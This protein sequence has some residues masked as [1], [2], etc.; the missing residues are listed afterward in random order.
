DRLDEGGNRLHVLG[1][2]LLKVSEIVPRCHYQAVNIKQ[3]VAASRGRQVYPLASHREADPLGNTSGRRACAEEQETLLGELLFGQTQR[4]EDA[5]Q[6][7]AGSA[8]YVVV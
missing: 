1:E 3:G 6:C 5:G 4:G 7:D 2:G 8:L